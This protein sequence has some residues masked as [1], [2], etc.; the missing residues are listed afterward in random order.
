MHMST[1]SLAA[2]VG[3]ALGALLAL[4]QLFRPRRSPAHWAFVGGMAVLALEALFCGM[5]GLTNSQEDI[6]KWQQLRIL[7]VS[8]V[9]GLWLLFSLNYSRGDARRFVSVWRAPLAALLF[10]LPG[11]AVLLRKHLVS[12]AVLNYENSHWVIVLGWAG[13]VVF[14]CVLVGSVLVVMNLE[15]T[16]RAAVGTMRWRIKF[17]L[18][19]IGVL[20]VVRIYT[21]SQAL[22]Y[23]GVDLQLE[24]LNSAALVVAAALIARSFFRTREFEVD[25]YPSQSVLQGSITVLIAGVYLVLVGALAKVAAYVGGDEQFALKAFI[26]LVSLVALA[27]LLQSDRVR[28]HLRRFVS[29][30]FQRPLYD[31]RMVW[32]KFTEGTASGVEQSDLCRSLV[33]LTAETFQALSV[34]IW[35]LDDKREALGLAASTFLPEGKGRAPDLRQPTAGL[36]LEHF[37]DHPEPVDIESSGDDWAASLREIHPS[38]FAHGGHRVCV[39]LVGQGEVIGVLTLGDRVGGTA[40]SLQDFDMLKCVGD[41]AAAG[42]RNVQLS[43]KLLQAKEL[44]AFQTMAA[45][46]VHDL[47]NAASTL[48][49]MLQNLPVHF[50][51]PAFREDSLRGISKTVTHIN[52]LIG[53]LSLLRHEQNIQASEMDLNEIV[54]SAV[55]GLEQ[56]VG[57]VLSKDLHPVPKVNLDREQ[58]VKVVTNLVLNATEAVPEGGHVRVETRLEANWVVL[59]VADDGCG[60]SEDFL[61]SGLFRPFQTTKKNGLGIGMFQTKMIV[62]GHGGRIAV[63]SEPGRGTTFQVFLPLSRRPQ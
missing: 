1:V 37:K 5:A 26:A 14:A 51:D 7:A 50:D 43:Q 57:S 58:I 12:V 33:R 10:M 59:V 55:A 20:F 29:R 60:M 30:N 22:L 39:P 63:A 19:G 17:M 49:L 18:L 31:Y 34:A 45:F 28:L 53:R 62:E 41:H 46:F 56:G 2:F 44:E 36:L 3:A 11:F 38:Q 23:R 13:V 54:S 16:F 52:R 27:I 21:S 25:V 8:L 4:H 15:R 40:F 42:L 9:P 32:R 24:M 6:V 47:K 61:A 35:L 48:N